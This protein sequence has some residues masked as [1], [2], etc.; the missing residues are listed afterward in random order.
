MAGIAIGSALA[1]VICVALYLLL[2]KH[3]KGKN[4]SPPAPV[5]IEYPRSDQPIATLAE[6]EN[7]YPVR[8]YGELEATPSTR[9]LRLNELPDGRN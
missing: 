4:R 5:Q 7:K 6:M 3:R 8:P 9:D 2:R 1:A